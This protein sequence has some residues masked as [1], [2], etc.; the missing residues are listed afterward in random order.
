MIDV[1][2]A[3]AHMAFE[4]EA[5]H[6]VVHAVQATQHR[7]LAAPGRSDEGRNGVFLDGNGR[8]A[9]GLEGPVVKLLDVTVDYQ[10]RQVLGS[11]ELL[12]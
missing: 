8:V 7:A 5:A 1:F 11:I 2:A 4:P 6:E 3:E 9:H 12:V 10:C